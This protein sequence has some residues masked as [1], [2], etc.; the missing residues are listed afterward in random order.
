MIKISSESRLIW[1]VRTQYWID[2]EIMN[3]QDEWIEKYIDLK[4]S[5][6]CEKKN[7]KVLYSS[8]SGYAKF[9]GRNF[10]EWGRTVISRLLKSWFNILILD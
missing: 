6:F 1:I 5:I 3:I 9:R 2:Q 10:S 7:V 4:K 8:N